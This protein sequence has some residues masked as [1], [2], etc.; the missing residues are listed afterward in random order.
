MN[1]DEKWWMYLSLPT[2]GLGPI[3]LRDVLAKANGCRSGHSDIPWSTLRY[4]DSS[5]HVPCILQL[6]WFNIHTILRS[7]YFR[8]W[9]TAL[10]CHQIV[11][12]SKSLFESKLWLTEL[13]EEQ[14][15]SLLPLAAIGKAPIARLPKP[16]SSNPSSHCL[17]TNQKPTNCL[18]QV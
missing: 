4:H 14:S 5:C 3:Q 8:A 12:A 10:Q 2:W 16:G 1:R 17:L 6:G 15:K 9:S 13:L 7:V 11:S 18:S